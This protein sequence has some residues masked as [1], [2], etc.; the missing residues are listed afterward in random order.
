MDAAR[1]Y[2]EKGQTDRAIKEYLKVVDHDPKDVRVWLKIGD[3]YAKK[4]AKQEAT[5]QSINALSREVQ[6]LKGKIDA[7]RQNLNEVDQ[8]LRQT[9]E[10]LDARI[11]K[12]EESNA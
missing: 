8:S 9:W 12:L 3:L 2:V 4:G 10:A 11:K 1:K 5:D 6:E 7:D